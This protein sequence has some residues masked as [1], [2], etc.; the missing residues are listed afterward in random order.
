MRHG[1]W[2]GA[3]AMVSQDLGNPQVEITSLIDHR[4]TPSKSKTTTEWGLSLY[5]N[6]GE[7]SLLFDT[8]SS[9]RFMDNAAVLGIDIGSVEFAV[10]SHGH[11]DHGG[12]LRL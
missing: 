6:C 3:C 11:F 4:K 9:G 5:V 10:L 7:F 8:G 2:P 12:I 1:V